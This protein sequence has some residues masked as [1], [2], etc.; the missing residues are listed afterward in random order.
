[1]TSQ[2]TLVVPFEDNRLAAVLFGEYDANLAM[3][4]DRLSI[5]VVAHGNVVTLNG[6]EHSC[7]IAKEVL[8]EFYNRLAEGET[9]SS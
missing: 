5:E 2:N 8:E 4:E 3:L 1:M 7:A 6:S 9:I